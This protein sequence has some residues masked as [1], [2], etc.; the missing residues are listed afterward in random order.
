M[1]VV[2]LLVRHDNGITNTACNLR[3]IPE[4]RGD[5]CYTR[6]PSDTT[7][8]NCRNSNAWQRRRDERDRES[9]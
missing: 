1:M 3:V 6:N 2:H 4:E 9:W 7:C 5:P 8:A